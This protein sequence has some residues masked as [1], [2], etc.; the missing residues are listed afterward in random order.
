MVIVSLNCHFTKVHL[1]GYQSIYRDSLINW[2]LLS[3]MTMC[4][5]TLNLSYRK[6]R[7]HC[8]GNPKK[9]EREF[10][11]TSCHFTKVYLSGY[12]SIY[13]DSWINWL[14]LSEIMMCEVTPNLS[15]CKWRFHCWRNPKKRE[16]EFL[17]TSMP[18]IHPTWKPWNSM[19]SGG[20]FVCYEYHFL[21]P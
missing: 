13:K 3:E 10:L 5:V 1:S 16:R 14:L 9:R 2:L 18:L 17:Y 4:E 6:W 8:W 19:Q 12:Q 21:T 11:Y 15:Y 7:F 20:F